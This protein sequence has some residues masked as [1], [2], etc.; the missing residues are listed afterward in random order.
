MKNQPSRATRGDRQLPLDHLRPGGR[1]EGEPDAPGP[2]DLR[3]GQSEG[4]AEPAAPTTPGA[5][6]ADAISGKATRSP[7]AVATRDHLEGSEQGPM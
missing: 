1:R 2:D 7:A 6:H 5:G 3:R 4:G